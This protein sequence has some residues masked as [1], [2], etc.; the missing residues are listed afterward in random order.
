MAKRFTAA[1]QAQAEQLLQDELERLNPEF[2]VI[3]VFERI[4]GKMFD[5]HAIDYS[6]VYTFLEETYDK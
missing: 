3:C 1:L 4:A 6:S 5:E 2:D